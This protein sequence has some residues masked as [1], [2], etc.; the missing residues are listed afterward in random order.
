MRSKV[1]ERPWGSF[2][3]YVLNEKCTVKIHTV[4][5]GSKCSLQ[6]HKKRSELFIPLDEGVVIEV[7]GKAFETEPGDEVYVPLGSRHRFS[8]RTEKGRILEI[9]FGK[10][11]EDDITRYEDEY[12]RV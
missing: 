10:F 5:R 6:S 11:D 12:G 1:S 4:K 7:G 3:Q 8:S 2:R 9:A